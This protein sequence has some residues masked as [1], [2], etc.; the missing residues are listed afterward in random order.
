[1]ETSSVSRAQELAEGVAG[2]WSAVPE[3]KNEI[4]AT[5]RQREAEVREEAASEVFGPQ[6]D[7]DHIALRREIAARIRAGG[8]K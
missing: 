8:K 5:I 2:K 4:A 6:F 7:G 3:W 1:M